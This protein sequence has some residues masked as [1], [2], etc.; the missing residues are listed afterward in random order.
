MDKGQFIF[1]GLPLVF[2]A[3]FAIYEFVEE[4]SLYTIKEHLMVFLIG[5][6]VF[7]PGVIASTILGYN[8][9]ET[10]LFKERTPSATMMFSFSY[11]ILCFWI[12]NIVGNLI[13]YFLQQL[14]EFRKRRKYRVRT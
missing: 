14:E 2:A 3:G 1:L 13:K 5:I 9:N 12:L 7:I 4:K 10:V 8:L 11:G 6:G